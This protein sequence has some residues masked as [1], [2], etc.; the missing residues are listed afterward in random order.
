MRLPGMA[1]TTHR[2][3]QLRVQAAPDAAGVAAVT[4]TP[5]CLCGT[6]WGGRHVLLRCCGGVPRTHRSPASQPRPAMHC[7]CYAA[8]CAPDAA[9]VLH[10]RG[11]PRLRS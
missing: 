4:A 1:R 9:A 3:Q 10:N 6:F 2:R 7:I 8:V 11:R 5:A